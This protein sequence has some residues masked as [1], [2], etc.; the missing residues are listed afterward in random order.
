MRKPFELL[1]ATTFIASHG[2][3]RLVVE[4][5]SL[6]TWFL[7][8]GAD[9][10]AGCLLDITPL[11]IAVQYAPLP[12]IKSLF[13]H[14]GS[15]KYGQLLH[16]AIWRELEDRLEVLAYI[17]GKGP[18]INDVMYQSRLDCYNQRR[19]FQLGTP[20][21]DA[22]AT[23]YLDVVQQLVA[24]GAHPLIEDSFGEIPLQR[25][26]RNGHSTVVEFL[27]PITETASPP[28]QQFTRGRRAQD[29]FR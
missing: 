2:W 25:A 10:N 1:I 7:S 14:G 17:I 20:L 6:T 22:A 26:E 15:I 8:H 4:D 23:G 16:Y 28:P 24:K 19:A 27:R 12:I 21:H 13:E 5:E 9:P 29:A 3:Y 18:P 11:S